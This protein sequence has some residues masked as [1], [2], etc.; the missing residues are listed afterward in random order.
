MGHY[1]VVGTVRVALRLALHFLVVA[2]VCALPIAIFVS[3][4]SASQMASRDACDIPIHEG[5]FDIRSAET[6]AVDWLPPRVQ[7]RYEIYGSPSIMTVWNSRWRTYAQLPMLVALFG[8]FF[9][10][11]SSTARV[12]R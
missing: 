10:L 12:D 8:A 5:G 11:R 4:D 6:L 9:A 3:I 1:S 7:C 2:T